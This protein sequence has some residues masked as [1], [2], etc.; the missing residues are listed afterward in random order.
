MNSF[1]VP[2]SCRLFAVMVAP[3]Y[4][5]LY[6]ATAA[7][8]EYSRRIV[9]ANVSIEEKPIMARRTFLAQLAGL[10]FFLR[11]GKADEAKNL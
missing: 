9:P 4:K 3:W 5:L 2:A 8:G 1:V 6:L 7:K 10:P 11:T